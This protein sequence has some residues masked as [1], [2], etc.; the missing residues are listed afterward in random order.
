MPYLSLE[1]RRLQPPNSCWKQDTPGSARL[2]GK[3]R[4]EAEAMLGE[5]PAGQHNQ[6]TWMWSSQSECEAGY[7]LFWG[8]W[9]HRYT[10]HW[11]FRWWW[12]HSSF[13]STFDDRVW[14][15][16]ARNWAFIWFNAPLLSSASLTACFNSRTESR[17]AILSCVSLCF[18]LQSSGLSKTII[19]QR[20]C[21]WNLIDR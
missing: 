10:F 9:L 21:I 2:W 4:S 18:S 17:V 19:R 15:T 14:S 6:W 16:A 5:T 20:K 8:C 1:Q 12:W 11:K 7:F 13:T 3:F